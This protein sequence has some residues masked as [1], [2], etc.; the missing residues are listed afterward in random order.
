M[1]VA[2]A[3]CR[4]FEG[5]YLSPYLCPAGVATVGYGS[6]IYESGLKVTLLDPPISKA[7]AEELLIW[8]INNRYLPAV[9]KLCPGLA[10]PNQLAALIDFTYNLGAGNLQAS[11][12]RKRVNLG[13]WDGARAQIRRWNKSRGRILKGL[14]VRR[15]AEAVML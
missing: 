5:L 9:L 10:D 2:A 12:L 6:T 14:T 8:S 15:E 3:L 7:R 1:Q 11:T 4:R 13:D